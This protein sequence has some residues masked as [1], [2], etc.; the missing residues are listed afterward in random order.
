MKFYG[1]MN[2]SVLNDNGNSEVTENTTQ[3]KYNYKCILSGNRTGFF[4]GSEHH[5]DTVP[6]KFQPHKLLP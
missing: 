6:F 5:P 2:Y 3:G 4:F 1:P